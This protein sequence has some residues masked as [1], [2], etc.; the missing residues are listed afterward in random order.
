MIVR[1]YGSRGIIPVSGEKF[2]KYGGNTACLAIRDKKSNEF[3]IFDAGTGL[4]KLGE[5]LIAIEHI[6]KIHIFLTHIHSDHISGLPFFLPLYSKKYN[7]IIYGPA[8]L[9]YN[10]KS[11]ILS[12]FKQHTNPVN[13]GEPVA[14][15]QIMELEETSLTVSNINIKTILLNHPIE[16]LGYRISVDETSICYLTDH[17][18]YRKGMDNIKQIKNNRYKEFILNTSMMIAD[19]QYLPDEYEMYKGWGHA[20]VNYIINQAIEGRVKRVVL[21]HHDPNRTDIQIDDILQHYRKLLIKK[22]IKLEIIAAKEIDE[23]TV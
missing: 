6:D 23:Y 15:I 10:L 20:P 4:K 5:D 14:D 2:K 7:I 18:P 13:L 9:I 16:N 11:E 1:V 19:A 17:E 21:T 22:N 12:L 3:F 8:S